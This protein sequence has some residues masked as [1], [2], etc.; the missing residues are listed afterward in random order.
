MGERCALSGYGRMGA[1]LTSSWLNRRFRMLPRITYGSKPDPARITGI[2]WTDS[3]SRCCLTMIR[4]CLARLRVILINFVWW[5]RVIF[6]V[7]KYLELKLVPDECVFRTSPK[8]SKNA[9]FFEPEM[10]FF[11]FMGIGTCSRYAEVWEDT[12]CWPLFL[13]FEDKKGEERSER[14]S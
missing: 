11:M 12:R 1:W 5:Y 14:S 7:R 6:E 13:S 2:V 3:R 9:Q 4:V 10:I 8:G